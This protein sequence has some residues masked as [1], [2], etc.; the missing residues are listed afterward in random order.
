VCGGDSHALACN[1]RGSG[2]VVEGHDGLYVRIAGHTQRRDQPV[3][4]TDVGFYDATDGVDDE[5]IGDDG[6][7]AVRAI[8]L[9]LPHSIADHLAASELD[10]F[11]ADAEILLHFGQQTGVR[12]AH[13]ITY[14]VDDGR[15]EHLRVG[16]SAYFHSSAPMTAPLNP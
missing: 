8:A 16:L 2:T 7:G 12:E 5:R 11:A 10:L 3:L 15:P 1:Y 4:D 6:V 13:A 9:A 14:A